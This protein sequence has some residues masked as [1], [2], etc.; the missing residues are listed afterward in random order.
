MLQSQSEGGLRNRKHEILS[1]AIDDLERFYVIYAI[2]K[3]AS[4]KHIICNLTNGYKIGVKNREV[5]G[6]Y[7]MIR[8]KL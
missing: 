1:D 8:C 6:S 5:S 2:L 3:M 4:I 7:E